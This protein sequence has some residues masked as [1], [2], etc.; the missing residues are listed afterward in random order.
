MWEGGREEGGREGGREGRTQRIEKTTE[1]G[2]MSHEEEDTC[3][4]RRRIHVT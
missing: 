3:Y 4:M 1:A 2:Y